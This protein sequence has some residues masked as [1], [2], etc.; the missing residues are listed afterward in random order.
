METGG[1]IA[2]LA[3]IGVGGYLGYEEIVRPYIAQKKLEKEAAVLAK[4]TGQP[5]TS[6][7]AQ[8]GSVGCKAF[9]AAEGVPSNPLVNAG[10][11]LAGQVAALAIVKGG[12]LA[13]KGLKETAK[14]TVAAA[15]AVGIAGEAVGHA[16]VAVVKAPI[17]LVEKLKFWGLDGIHC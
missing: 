15:K 4:K 9:A 16:A 13:L 6:V 7:L 12:P 11:G 5:Y 8:L 10:C 14:G 3:L 1:K 17:K 2:L